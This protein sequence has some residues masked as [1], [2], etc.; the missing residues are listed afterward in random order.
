MVMNPLLAANLP[1]DAA[2][3]F[4][5]VT[6]LT[7][8]MSLLV[9]R[10]RRSGDRGGADRT[11]QGQS[12]QAQHGRRH[13]HVAP[14]RARLRQGRRARGRAHPVQGQRRDRAGA[15]VGQRRFRPR[16]H[17]LEPA[18]DP[19]AG[20][21][22]RARQVRSSRPLPVLPDVPSLAAA[23]G[24][25]GFDE[26]ATW[27]GLLAPARTPSDVIERCSGRSRASMPSPA[28]QEK[29]TRAGIFGVTSTPAEFPPTSAPR[30]SAGARSSATTRRYGRID[31][32]APP[33]ALMLRSARVFASASRST[34]AA[35]AGQRRPF[36]RDVHTPRG[37]C[38]SSSLTQY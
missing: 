18:A 1:Y 30:P 38:S 36:L 23:T 24:L 26:S 13:D 27:I 11:S 21:V 2:K 6:L 37:V 17:G 14:R 35:R 33:S 10:Q 31:S 29:L 25:P 20:T 32:P 5:P 16:Q 7:R 4:A 19:Q 28:F 12:R 22:P 8:N 34:R 15:V 9:V 3:D